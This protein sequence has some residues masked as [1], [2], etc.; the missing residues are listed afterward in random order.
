MTCKIAFFFF[1]FLFFRGMQAGRGSIMK[2][3]RHKLHYLNENLHLFRTGVEP[4]GSYFAWAPVLITEL[5]RCAHTHMH[6]HTY[7]PKY[8]C[9]DTKGLKLN[10]SVPK[11]LRVLVNGSLT[12]LVLGRRSASEGLS[13]KTS[14][15]LSAAHF[16]GVLR[17]GTLPCVGSLVGSWGASA[18]SLWSSEGTELPQAW[19]Y[20]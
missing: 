14:I 5:A 1:S 6:S 2:Q 8:K 4:T 15:A 9:T 13:A 7:L 10:H 3:T 20:E 12:P 16:R 19:I 18:Y 17:A 11:V